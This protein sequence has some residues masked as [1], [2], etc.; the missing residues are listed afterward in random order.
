MS[1]MK[2]AA[3]GTTPAAAAPAA[4]AMPTTAPK[5]PTLDAYRARIKI[6][7]NSLDFAAEEQPQ[8]FMEVADEHVYAQSRYDQARDEL[9]RKDAELGRETRAAM[10]TAGQKPTEGSVADVVLG[11][12]DHLALAAKVSAAKIEVDEW[13]ALRSAL[14]HRKSM[15][16]ELATLYSAGYFTTGSASG[17]RGA[18][19]DAQY[20]EGREAMA[21]QRKA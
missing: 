19:R 4:P 5:A 3:A 15:I 20:K 16:R 1:I 17:A 21:A 12:K 8:L 11:H 7:R 10:V 14:E 13:G 6:D 2:R 18:V 9:T